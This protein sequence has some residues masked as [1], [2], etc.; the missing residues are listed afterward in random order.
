MPII[1]N[2]QEKR[3]KY[4][5]GIFVLVLLVTAFVVWFG[6]FREEGS[7]QKSIIVPQLAPVVINFDFLQSSPFFK[8]AAPFEAIPPLS[9]GAAV[10]RN[11]PFSPF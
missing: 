4:F 11:N 5:I 7:S 9:E 6:F 2:L 1:F 3:Q 8:E 10:G